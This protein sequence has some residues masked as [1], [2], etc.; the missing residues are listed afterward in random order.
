LSDI[1]RV[2]MVYYGNYTIDSTFQTTPT[3]PT[4][5]CAGYFAGNCGIVANEPTPK[6]KHTMQTSLLTGPLTTSVRWR[7]VGGT[8]IDPS[9][10]PAGQTTIG[11]LSDDIG[12][13]NYVDVTL[14]YAVNENLDLTVGVQNITG[15]DA[16]LLGSTVNEQANTFPATYETLGRQLFVGA[17]VRF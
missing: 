13:F 14:Q 9:A 10:F 3:A 6:Y 15:K 2:S 8:E 5:E 11:D 4:I 1:G 12:M 16:P 17:S 7:L